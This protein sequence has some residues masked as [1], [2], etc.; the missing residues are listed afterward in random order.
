MW[1]I[2]YDMKKSAIFI[3]VAILVSQ[4]MLAVIT[5][6]FLEQMKLRH[7]TLSPLL[8]RPAEW[9]L[10]LSHG[11][12]ILLHFIPVAASGY[13]AL[14]IFSRLR[15]PDYDP[16]RAMLCMFAIALLQ[17]AFSLFCTLCFLSAF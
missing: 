12:G 14:R 17:V 15:R 10:V 6:V 3:V 11:P 2:A 1:Y 16:T 4:V 5:T 13:V 7:I 9:G 8:P